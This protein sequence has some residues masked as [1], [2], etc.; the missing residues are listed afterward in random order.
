MCDDILEQIPVSRYPQ[1]AELL[2]IDIAITSIQRFID[3]EALTMPALK[4]SPETHCVARSRLATLYFLKARL[5]WRSRA[6]RP[7]ARSLLHDSV[8]EQMGAL[9]TLVGVS[10]PASIPGD[11]LDFQEQ[12]AWFE[13]SSWEGALQRHY[14]SNARYMQ[15]LAEQD[16]KGSVASSRSIG[17]RISLQAQ[18]PS[19]AINTLRGTP[20]GG[21]GLLE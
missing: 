9:L 8:V 16:W 13:V 14:A 11:P 19:I 15:L 18:M 7:I 5:L 2:P 4:Q 3:R 1:R 21:S 10:I 12:Q 6:S 20:S 17:V